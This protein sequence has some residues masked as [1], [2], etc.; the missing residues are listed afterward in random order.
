MGTATTRNVHEQILA[1]LRPA[2]D[3]W[4]KGDPMAYANLFAEELTYFAPPT[5]GR[6]NGVEALRASYVPIQGKIN[7]PRYEM[8]NANLQLHGDVGVLTYNL[9][10]Y[11]RD[12]APSARWN[13]TE[14]YRR[15][16][17]EWRIIHAHWSTR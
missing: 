5:G 13:A 9:D 16:G 14:V 15:D 10:E 6:L 1:G 12:T 11:A 4:Y 17:D 7:V 8:S 3:R 2:L